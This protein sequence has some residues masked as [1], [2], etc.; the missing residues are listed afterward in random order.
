MSFMDFDGLSYNFIR[1][2]A[3]GKIL[4]TML[5]E[6]QWSLLRAYPMQ[7]HPQAV[8]WA[9]QDLLRLQVSFAYKYWDRPNLQ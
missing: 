3:N 5:T 9:D 4:P 2:D 8:T 7:V 1:Y 6:Y